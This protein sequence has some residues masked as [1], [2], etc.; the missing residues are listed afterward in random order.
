[1]AVV[2]RFKQE[3][4]YGFFSPPKRKNVT[5]VEKWP[6]AG[7]RLYKGMVEA[8]GVTSSGINWLEKCKL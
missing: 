5:V 8:F 7:V 3:S 4:M 2:E 6:L 1:M